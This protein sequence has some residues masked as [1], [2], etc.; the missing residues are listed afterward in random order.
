MLFRSSGPEGRI[1]RRDIREAAQK[2]AAEDGAEPESD[3]ADASESLKASAE[4]EALPKESIDETAM[5]DGPA[6]EAD[7]ADE[8]GTGALNGVEM[9]DAAAES[10]KASA[11]A[12]DLVRNRDRRRLAAKVSADELASADFNPEMAPD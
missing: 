10:D 2:A 12:S 7:S 5:A 11:A 6:A 1:L 8:A 9:P 3:A 4:S